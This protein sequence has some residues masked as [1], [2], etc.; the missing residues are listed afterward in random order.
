MGRLQGLGVTTWDARSLDYGSYEF[1]TYTRPWASHRCRPWSV[2]SCKP[3]SKRQVAN[4]SRHGGDVERLN[5]YKSLVTV[6]ASH[7]GY[8]RLRKVLQTCTDLSTGLAL[9]R[10]NGGDGCACSHGSQ[11]VALG[12]LTDFD[13]MRD[14]AAPCQDAADGPNYAVRLLP[15]PNR[16]GAKRPLPGP[17]GV[18]GAAEAEKILLRH[19]SSSCSCVW[20]QVPEGVCHLTDL[21]IR[22]C[23]ASGSMVYCFNPLCS[24]WF[25]KETFCARMVREH[26]G[27]MIDAKSMGEDLKTFCVQDDFCRPGK[28]PRQCCGML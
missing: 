21:R 4:G 11:A 8:V 7:S 17:H 14:R 23:V 19:C 2:P 28:E 1:E 22:F 18:R 25:T 20:G 6:G 13:H 16:R 5:S 15:D 3:W 10:R 27:D 26:G 12:L 24:T 9:G